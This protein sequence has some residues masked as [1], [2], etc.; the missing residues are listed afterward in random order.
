[1]DSAAVTRRMELGKRTVR[2]PVGRRHFDVLERL[3]VVHPHDLP[4]G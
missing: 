3:A 2:E 4:A 1:M